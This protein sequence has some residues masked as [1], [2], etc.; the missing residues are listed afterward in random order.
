MASQWKKWTEGR[1]L[2]AFTLILI[3]GLL[4]LPHFGYGWSLDLWDFWPCILILT[5]ISILGKG[6]SR[7][8]EAILWILFGFLFLGSSLGF[9][10]F[11]FHLFW[12][13]LVIAAGV[14]LLR[15]SLNRS[16]PAAASE[17]G[18]GPKESS[19][20]SGAPHIF[21]FLG[22][23][24]HRID[25]KRFRG[26]NVT[27]FL[28]SGAVDLRN[29]DMEDEAVVDTLSFLGK[30]EILVP[31]GWEI[32]LQGTSMLGNMKNETREIPSQKSRTK[33]GEPKRLIVKG[34]AFLGDVEVKNG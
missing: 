2:L 15:Q 19:G 23:N 17:Q 14:L 9:Y 26:V 13:L 6:G 32:L 10:R 22:G 18:S 5:G 12:P 3:G 8:V 31:E 21:W 4:L 27:S 25:S 16:G 33:S 30:I 20:D 29:A 34:L 24:R 28:S 1:L 7:R 11:H